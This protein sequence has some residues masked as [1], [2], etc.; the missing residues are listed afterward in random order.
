MGRYH[1]LRNTLILLLLLLS[2]VSTV[3]WAQS[4]GSTTAGITGTVTD[5]QGNVIAGAGISAKNSETN[6]IREART[7]EDGA[8]LLQQLPPGVYEIM[9]TAEGFTT[10][11]SRL[12]LS[13]GNTTRLDFV[14]QVGATSEV[15]EVTTTNII[16]EA[17]TEASTN[18]DRQRIDNLPINRRNFLDFSL[19]TPRVVADRVPAQGAA[20]TSGLSFNGQTARVNNITIDGLDNNDLGTG[21]VRSTF[22]QDAVQEFQVVSNSYSAEFGRALGGVVNIV[23]RGGTN[24]YHGNLFFI[25]RNDEI[26]ARDVFAPFKPDYKQY[27]FG[28]TLSGPIKKD[29]AFFFTSFERLSIKQNNFVTI[30]DQTVRSANQLGFVLRNGPIPF[31]I[32]T[33]SVLA[34]MDARIGAND[35]LWVR[36]NFG[37]SYNGALEPFGGLIGETN[38]GI[39]KLD[40][41]TVAA[42]NTYISTKLNL[43]NETRF[44]YSRR[45]QNV[46]PLEGGP[47]IRLVSPEGLATFGRSTFSPQPRE[48]K[49]YQIIDN[50]SLTRGRHQMKFGVDFNYYSTPD[51]K[52]KVPIFGGGFALFLPINFSA[53]TGMPGLPSFTG[54][55]AF[56]PSLRTPEQRSFLTLLSSLLPGMVQGFPTGVPLANLSLPT[57][58]IQGFGDTGIVINAKLFSTFFQDDIKIRPNLVLKAGV[59]YDINRVDLVPD[60]NGNF[61]PRLAFSY[62]PE[63]LPKLSV[64][65]AYGLFFATAVTGPSFIVGLTNSTIKLGVTPFPFSVLPFSRPGH[66]FPD[67]NQLPPGLNF[68]PQ[69]S[70]IFTY[71]PSTRNSYTQQVN[72]GFDYLFGNNAALSGSYQFVR[73]IRLLGQRNI[74]PIVRPTTNPVES[75]LIGRVD[76]SKGDITEFESAY[77]S[78]FHGFTISFNRRLSNR[79]G[80]L[81]NYTVSKTI[82]NFIDIRPDIS[83][84]DDSLQPRNERALS[85]Q[86]VR[87]RVVISGSWELSYTQ[88][89]FLRDFQLSTIV[90]LN[91]GRPYNLLAGADLNRSG[92]FPPGDRPAGLGRNAGISPGFANVDLRLTRTVTIKD[93]YRVQGIVEVFN[94][95]NRV[96]ISE[97][98]RIFP[99]DAQG[100]FV[101]PPKEGGRFVATADRF[102]N[103]FSPRQFQIGVK[104]TF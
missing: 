79:V 21:S 92:D 46:L 67:S 83:E 17:K 4:G 101:L 49:L 30:G 23:T 43:V 86:D 77:D 3:V 89:P 52:T 58:Y 91:S 2:H 59:R 18:I 12:E 95:F 5:Q 50:V 80:F 33:T 25:L 93:R 8:F 63:R 66:N 97:L 100:R 11:T 98:D 32:G 6:F 76:P 85:L 87:Q 47:Q 61:S 57:A 69:F 24:D 34:R 96:N 74:N 70:Q 104:F 65:G 19:T 81:A 48:L 1:I 29:K 55:Q 54:L 26:S 39:Q 37:G 31:S 82:D 56:D 78:Y 103:A 73:G 44:F 16:E 20:A 27:Q 62:R 41:N 38:G 90:N 68:I 9:V 94:M 75:T 7:G 84:T 45:D 36:Y 28:T 64:H 53:L 13:L 22:S 102:R 15:V 72:F 35:T 14:V 71:A 42:N 60:N 40:D 51:L 10:Q 99:P 88:N